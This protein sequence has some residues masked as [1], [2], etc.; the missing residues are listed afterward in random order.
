MKTV[1]KYHKKTL[2]EDLVFPSELQF[3]KIPGEIQTSNLRIQLDEDRPKEQILCFFYPAEQRTDLI[4]AKEN[5]KKWYLVAKPIL[6]IKS[7]KLPRPKPLNDGAFYIETFKNEVPQ[8]IEIYKFDGKDLH[9]SGNIV[10][11]TI[12]DLGN[13][14]THELIGKGISIDEGDAIK[15]KY[16]YDLF[17]VSP[18]GKKGKYILRGIVAEAYYEWNETL[19]SYIFQSSS[20]VVPKEAKQ[21]EPKYFLEANREQ[22][23]KMK[24][25]G[26][27]KTKEMLKNFEF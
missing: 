17:Q 13:N 3:N 4:V 22:L 24:K 16:R 23:D 27:S 14:L 8:Q 21:L 5:D 19:G 1:L 15:I 2:P 26:N 9:L 11:N 25:R 18:E 12:E 7:D 20:T 10:W 6:E